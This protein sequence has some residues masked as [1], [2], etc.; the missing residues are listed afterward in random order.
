MATSFEVLKIILKKHG[1]INPASINYLQGSEVDDGSC[2]DEG[3]TSCIQ[4][5]VLDSTLLRR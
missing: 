4:N 3:F 5:A 1:C 2:I